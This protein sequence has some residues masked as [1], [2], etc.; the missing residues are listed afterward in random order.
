M[1]PWKMRTFLLLPRDDEKMQL[2]IV[3]NQVVSH[4]AEDNRS[5]FFLFLSVFHTIKIHR[6]TEHTSHK[7][8]ADDFSTADSSCM[9]LSMVLKGCL[10]CS[11][12]SPLPNCS[13]L[14]YSCTSKSLISAHRPQNHQMNWN[15]ESLRT[16]TS[17]IISHRR[18]HSPLGCIPFFLAS[19]KPNSFI[20]YSVLVP[21]CDF[22]CFSSFWWPSLCCIS[23]QRHRESHRLQDDE[24]KKSQPACN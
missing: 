3:P 24:K 11:L 14:L 17:S 19:L 13:F 12:R 9:R 1:S 7:K 2:V 15:E 22:L 23:Q 16:R 20:I 6:K 10:P 4:R 5:W 8:W 18:H 21:L